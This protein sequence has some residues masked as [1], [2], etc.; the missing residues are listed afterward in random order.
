MA[1]VS[2]GRPGT[3]GTA[4]LSRQGSGGREIQVGSSAVDAFD[5]DRLRAARIAAGMSQRDLA[6]KLLTAAL[7]AKGNAR[8]VLTEDAWARAVETERVRIVTYEQGTHTP[9]VPVLGRLATALGVDAFELFREG[10]PRTLVTLR[11]RLGLTQGDVA[12]QL[13]T[14]GR[15]YYSRIEQGTAGLNDDEDRRRLAALLQVNLAE[16]RVLT[17]G[18]SSAA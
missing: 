5:P 16:V 3:L 7:A 12:A 13:H 15:A 6:V 11:S 10:T 18:P 17:A 1:R 4:S 9:R 8:P 2:A 14:V